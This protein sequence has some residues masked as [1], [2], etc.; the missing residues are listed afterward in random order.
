MR[1]K[2]WI[3][4]LVVTVP[5]G[6]G[7]FLDEL[8]DN[9]VEIT[10]LEKAAQLLTS[11]YS[12]ASHGFL[13]WMTDNVDFTFGVNIRDNHAQAFFWQ[14]SFTAADEQDSP[15]YFWYQTYR[16]ISHANEVLAV[17]DELPLNGEQGQA[18]KSAIMGEAYLIR[19][20][21]H[22]MLA[23]VFAPPYNAGDAHRKLGLPYVTTPETEFFGQYERISLSQFYRLVEQDLERGLALV[24][25]RF[26]ANSGKYHFTKSAGYALASR[27]Y[28]FKGEYQTCIAYS[29]SLLGTTS[30]SASG[31]VRDMISDQFQDASSSIDAYAQLYNS[32]DLAANILMIRKESFINYPN[33]GHGMTNEIYGQV[34]QSNVFER[35]DARANPALVK[36]NN[37]VLPVR[38]EFLFRRSSLNSDVGFAYHISPV[39]TGEEVLLN[40]AESKVYTGNVAGAL[41]D[42]QVLAEKRYGRNVVVTI[43][44]A[45]RL[46][47]GNPNDIDSD[48]DR[49]ALSLLIL[50][51]K[52]REFVLTGMRWFDLR[53]GPQISFGSFGF[54]PELFNVEHFD[55]EIDQSRILRWNDPRRTLQLPRSA[56]EVGGLEP[57][58]R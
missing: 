28:L 31:F 52:R 46:V 54:N 20:Y 5:F 18:R 47:G 21:S 43:E 10:D 44:H 37:A 2:F 32:P 8:P 29:D 58:E 40:R 42:L 38:H 34:M 30:T 55:P 13:E 45:R 57:N 15:D 48:L 53:R 33:F 22:F 26:Y 14:E 23:N 49:L 12:E 56:I 19:A 9:R 25:D 50:E 16:A 7:E 39:L 11:G 35:T 3:L 17:I 4:I 24:S 36:G 41:Q 27:Y 6:C 51:E 1:A